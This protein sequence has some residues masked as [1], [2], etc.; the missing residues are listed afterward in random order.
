MVA[1]IQQQIAQAQQQLNNGPVAPQ[2]PQQQFQG[3]QFAQIQQ[4]IAQA[5]QQLNNGPVAP[6]QPQQQFQGQQFAQIQ[7]QIAQAQQQ[8]GEQKF[9]ALEQFEKIQAQ[10][11]AAQQQLTGLPQQQ[12]EDINNNFEY[13]E[14]AFGSFSLAGDVTAIQE[15]CQSCG[16]VDVEPTVYDLH[17]NAHFNTQQ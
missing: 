7:Q 13:V 11:A 2:Q 3:Q 1:Q 9:S 6:Q 5:Q 10:I 12:S 8:Q 16:H 17:F 4:Q 15:A 14:S